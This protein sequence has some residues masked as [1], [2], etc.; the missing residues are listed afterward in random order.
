[1]LFHPEFNGPFET[2]TD[3]N[4]VGCGAMLAQYHVGQL[5]Q[6]CYASRSFTPIESRWPTA[7]QELF[8][9]KWALEHYRHYLINRKFKDITD[10][11]NLKLLSTIALQNSKLARWCLSLAEFDFTIENRAGKNN[12]IPDTFFKQKSPA[13]SFCRYQC[14]LHSSIRFDWFFHFK[15]IIRYPTCQLLLQW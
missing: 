1:M 9:V 15:A 11:E 3:A 2:Y 14:F 10:H 13:Y 4:E 8:A 5:R 6:V 7:R 12:I